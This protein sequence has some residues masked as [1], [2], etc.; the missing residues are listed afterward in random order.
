MARR[1]KEG[2]LKEELMELSLQEL[3]EISLWEQEKRD[4]E[5][6]AAVHAEGKPD[7]GRVFRSLVTCARDRKS[8]LCCWTIQALLQ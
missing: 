3:A 8:G 5:S 6:R 4:L 1:D 7:K 2:F